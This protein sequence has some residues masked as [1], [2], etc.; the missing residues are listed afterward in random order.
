MDV[1]KKTRYFL[2]EIAERV[3]YAEQLK[4]DLI[5]GDVKT[6]PQASYRWVL[7]QK[8]VTLALSGARAQ[9]EI[10]D[11]VRAS[12]IVSYS[13]DTLADVDAIHSRDFCPA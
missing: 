13:K 9:K 7:D 8:G 10:Q 2:K 4:L 11:A 5:H 6:L 12:E 1:S 3:D